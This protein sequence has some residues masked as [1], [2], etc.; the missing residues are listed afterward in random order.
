MMF[1]VGSDER[2]F[3]HAR[4]A[5]ASAVS[6]LRNDNYLDNNVGPGKAVKG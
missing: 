4:S 5:T 6:G 3:T 1:V 2:V